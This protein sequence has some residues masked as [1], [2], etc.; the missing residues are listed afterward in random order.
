MVG[1]PVRDHGVAGNERLT[2][3][4]GVVLLVL[5]AVELVTTVSLRSMMALHVFI[6]VALVGPLV[7][8]LGSVGYRFVRYYTGSVA[9]VRK[10][11][12]RLSLRILAV[13]LVATTLVLIGSGGGLLVTGPAQPGG[14]IALHNVSTLIWLPLIVI[15]AAAYV[16]RIPREVAPDVRAT[17]EVE[18]S[19]A[20][21]RVGVTIGALT[22]GAIAAVFVLPTDV[23]WLGWASTVHQ[24]PAPLIV[25]GIFA[26]VA[27]LAI[28][29]LRWT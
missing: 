4:A 3:W 9:Y 25:G 24:V 2:A 10:G 19:G 1:P 16:R 27:L 13:P 12:P 6:G 14:L 5:L 23:P 11:P 15:H 28:R 22:A 7:I 17:P 8:K 18:R 20:R 29:P 21:L 26:V